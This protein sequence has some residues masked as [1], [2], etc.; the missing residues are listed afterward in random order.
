MQTSSLIER[1]D[2]AEEIAAGMAL[3]LA[4]SKDELI[5]IWNRDC[6]HFEGEAR[7]RLQDIY[8][9][10]LLQFAPLQRAG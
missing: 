6:E 10:T 5:S 8:G 4:T 7:Q 3:S 1:A 9:D 2:Y